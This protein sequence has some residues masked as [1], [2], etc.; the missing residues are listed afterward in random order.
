MQVLVQIL[1]YTAF[2]HIG[3]VPTLNLT[4]L[5]KLDSGGPIGR[6]ISDTETLVSIPNNPDDIEMDYKQMSSVMTTT[7]SKEDESF[8]LPTR[9]KK[10]I[11][12]CFMD[13]TLRIDVITVY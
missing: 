1:N 13:I 2:Y 3:V 5:T 6:Y 9:G 8:N 10:I 7:S 11:I 12:L 4:A